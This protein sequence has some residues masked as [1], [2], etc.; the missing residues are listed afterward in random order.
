M[1]KKILIVNDTQDMGRS[2]KPFFQHFGDILEDPE[3]LTTNPDSI[4]LVVFTG[5]SDVYPDYYNEPKLEGCFCDQDRDRQEMLIFHDAKDHKIP[6]FGIC[7]GAQFLCVMDGGALVQH[8]TGHQTYHFMRTSQERFEVSSAHHQMMI[9]AGYSKTI[10]WTDPCLSQ[11]YINGNGKNLNYI[12]EEP[13]VV[14]F[15]MI[16]AI[17]V[18]YH[19]EIMNPD[20]KGYMYCRELVKRLLCNE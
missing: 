14:E 7:R 20:S 13:E 8:I 18:Q 9:P 4:G 5:G 16:R 11:I 6:M 10:G 2:Y 3:Q 12:K 19:P 17:G 1:D 15:P